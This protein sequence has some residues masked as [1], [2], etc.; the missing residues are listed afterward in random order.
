MNVCTC[1]SFVLLKCKRKLSKR[2]RE[3]VSKSEQ[4]VR[5]DMEEK[6]KGK[7]I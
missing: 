5:E 4:R 7:K 6:E 1:I 2:G 3:K